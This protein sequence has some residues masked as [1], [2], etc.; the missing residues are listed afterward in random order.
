MSLLLPSALLLLVLGVL[1]N[2]PDDPLAADHLAFIAYF[3][4][5]GPDFHTE[6]LAQ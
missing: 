6:L 1:A 4:D 5:A 3:L 2:D